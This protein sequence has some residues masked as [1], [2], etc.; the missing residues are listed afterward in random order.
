MDEKYYVEQ[1]KFEELVKNVAQDFMGVYKN[2]NN[3][4]EEVE[5][6]DKVI[7]DKY[8]LGLH[9]VYFLWSCYLAS[10]IEERSLISIFEE[11]E[12]DSDFRPLALINH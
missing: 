5:K 4:E 6:R 2:L 1:K 10:V 8:E 9:Q 11:L 7:M 12:K 3:L